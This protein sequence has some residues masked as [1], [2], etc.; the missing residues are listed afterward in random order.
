MRVAKAACTRTALC[1]TNPGTAP[2]RPVALRSDRRRE[3]RTNA[4]D[5][6]F[7]FF[8]GMAICLIDGL[9]SFPQVMKM[10]ELMGLIWKNRCHCQTDGVLPIGD[11]PTDHHVL[12]KHLFGCSQQARQFFL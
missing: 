12:G 4:T 7:Q 2:R 3:P 1:T 10:A 11:H 9:G 8:F 6:L 5:S